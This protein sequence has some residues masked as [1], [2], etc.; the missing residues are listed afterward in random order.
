MKALV[1]LSYLAAVVYLFALWAGGGILWQRI[2]GL[3]LQIVAAGLFNWARKATLSNRFTAA[4]DTDEPKFLV[5]DGPYRFVRHPF[6]VS[7]VLFWLGSSLAANSLI[8]WL[9]FMVLAAAYVT[10]ALLEEMKFKKS[11][12]ADDYALYVRRTGFFFP[13]ISAFARRGRPEGQLPPQESGS[14][15]IWRREPR[16]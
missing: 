13:R 5:K 7:Y 4:F 2:A 8:L 15:R 10:A 9:L 3:C 6:Y 16:A 14:G 12:F 11:S 1:A